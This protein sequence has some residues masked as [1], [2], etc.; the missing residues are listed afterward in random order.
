MANRLFVA[1]FERPR[2]QWVNIAN[3]PPVAEQIVAIGGGSVTI[4]NPFSSKTAVIRVHADSI[5]S[6]AIGGSGVTAAAT[7]MRMPADTTEY[8]SVQP[9]QYIAV[10]SNT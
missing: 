5:C 1:E 4:T 10:I 2:N 8:F 3:A 9:N 7:N 6:I